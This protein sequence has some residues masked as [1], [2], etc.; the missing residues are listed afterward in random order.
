MV[1]VSLR[2]LLVSWCSLEGGVFVTHGPKNWHTHGSVTGTHSGRPYWLARSLFLNYQLSTV[3]IRELSTMSGLWRTGILLIVFVVGFG[4]VYQ[5]LPIEEWLEPE[6]LSSYLQKFG[7]AGP[8]LLIGMMTLAVV[9]SPIPSLPLDLAAGAAYGPFWGGVYVLL[10]AELGAIVSFLIG[11]ALGK[12]VIGGWLGRDVTFCEQCSDHHLM[13]I[14]ALVRLVP[15]FSFDIVSYGA[16]LTTM[17]LRAFALATLVGMI[18]P[19]FTFTYLGS[20][21]VS[22]DGT[23]VLLG[24]VAVGLFLLL[25]KWIVKYRTTWWVRALQGSPIEVI[26]PPVVKPSKKG[27]TGCAWCQNEL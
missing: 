27:Q 10:G 6:W 7:W 19:T 11:R 5:L 17:S 25:P 1:A 3:P 8:L 15:L 24:L 22:I 23:M 12:D 4:G 13:G 16:G 9:I 14:V 2:E 26:E 18:P 21:V 20:S